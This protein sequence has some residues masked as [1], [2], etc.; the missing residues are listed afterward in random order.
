MILLLLG[1]SGCGKSL[2]E[3]LLVTRR[4]YE[5]VVTYTTRKK[6]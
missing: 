3:E 4:G 6:T 2:I 1:R 5:K